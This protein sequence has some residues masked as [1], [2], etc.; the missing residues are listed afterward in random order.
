MARSDRTLDASSRLNKKHLLMKADV[1]HNIAVVVMFVLP[2]TVYEIIT[3]NL[4]KWSRIE[5]MTFQKVGRYH[6]LQNRQ[7]CY[8]M[9]F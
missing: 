4:S 5:S 3:F 8:W 7:I 9:A 6:E 2:A 1:Q